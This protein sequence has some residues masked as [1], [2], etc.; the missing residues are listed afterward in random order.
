M[1]HTCAHVSTF[2]RPLTT[3]VRLL[4]VEGARLPPRTRE[5]V[6]PSDR[7][8]HVCVRIHP[9]F[10][11]G[12]HSGGNVRGRFHA[13][14]GRALPK[15]G[16]PVRRVREQ[17]QLRTA[18]RH[19]ARP[20]AQSPS[21]SCADSRQLTASQ[22][23]HTKHIRT[24]DAWSTRAFTESFDCLFPIAEESPARQLHGAARTQEGRRWCRGCG[25]GRWQLMAANGM[26]RE[27][28]AGLASDAHRSRAADLCTRAVPSR[29]PL[30]AHNHIPRHNANSNT[31]RSSTTSV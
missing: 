15:R 21:R 7:M 8:H 27:P 24:L 25:A 28:P 5:P 30:V 31:S 29:P 16:P 2:G 10:W 17:A 4:E 9:F 23:H 13:G 20:H 14:V 11:G 6:R 18:P 22:P 1:T 3:G 19:P 12:V 26:H